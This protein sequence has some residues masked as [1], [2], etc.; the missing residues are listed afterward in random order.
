VESIHIRHIVEHDGEIRVTGL[1]VVEGQEVEVAV[2]LTPPGSGV[3]LAANDLLE[4]GLV[5]MWRDR[6][7]LGTSEDYARRL[8][9]QAQ[10]RP[11]R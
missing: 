1:P 5:G 7:D 10:R 2:M 9:E 11:E 4:S 6:T 8:R 3:P